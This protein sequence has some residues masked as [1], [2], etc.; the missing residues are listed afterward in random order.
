[1]DNS[2][3]GWLVVVAATAIGAGV[4]GLIAWGIHWFYRQGI[5][6][7]T[8]VD[9]VWN[10]IM[11]WSLIVTGVLI[12]LLVA[13]DMMWP[14]PAALIGETLLFG[15]ALSAAGVALF[16]CGL[17]LMAVEQRHPWMKT[18]RGSPS[19]FVFALSFGCLLL[20]GGLAIIVP[21]NLA[22]LAGTAGAA[23]GVSAVLGL[24]WL[25][26][27]TTDTPVFYP[28]PALAPRQPP[29]PGGSGDLRAPSHARQAAMTRRARARKRTTAF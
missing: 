4:I 13:G 6:R 28:R 19:S 24:H 17:S 8:W 27:R 29:R 3:L 22:R 25:I 10:T 21:E 9:G 15:A 18:P 11:R 20:A 23:L 26:R 16:L 1:M 7:P 2:F 12:L 14:T 5:E